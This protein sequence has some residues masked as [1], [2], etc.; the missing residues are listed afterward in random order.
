[1]G[2][3]DNLKSLIS[4]LQRN[5][6]VYDSKDDRLRDDD[7]L[8]TLSGLS[9]L[10]RILDIT[11]NS[12]TEGIIP[13]EQSELEI[14]QT[15]VHDK[16]NGD[17]EKLLE[18]LHSQEVLQSFNEYINDYTSDRGTQEQEIILDDIKQ[19]PT[20][21]EKGNS[22]IP[23]EQNNLN[24]NQTDSDE[25]SDIVQ[26]Y[27]NTENQDLES[28][29][30]TSIS[31]LTSIFTTP[32]EPY[33]NLEPDEVESDPF[34]DEP[35]LEDEVLSD[36]D[37]FDDEPDIEDEYKE[38]IQSE[39]GYSDEDP[40]DDEPEL[41]EYEE[42]EEPQDFNEDPFDDEP[43]LEDEEEEEEEEEEPQ[44]FNEDP[45]DDE[46][47]LEDEY[48]EE[49]EDEVLSDEDPFDDEPELEED[50]EE[51]E[52]EEEPQDFNEDPFDDEPELEEDI[53]NDFEEETETN[54]A[55]VKPKQQNS[56][57]TST[58]QR[59]KGRPPRNQS[60][61]WVGQSSVSHTPKQEP[62]T[63]PVEPKPIKPIPKE[64]DS[65]DYVTNQ[66]ANRLSRL[67]RRR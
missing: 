30:K 66:I 51:F 56:N 39:Q 44:D 8:P 67:K 50:E 6:L 17:Y 15:I 32:Q 1:M 62:K 65:M 60:P 54:Q 36:E 28:P 47:E 22:A 10:F 26:A 33:T 12:I 34:D 13:T 19:P 20:L 48:E 55:P 61:H 31:E 2:R 3:T 45:F 43:E 14:F 23:T 9:E 37:P 27:S 40:F 64:T 24:T 52:E 58:R 7:D 49:S 42:E 18:E 63:I 21:H 4:R 11:N 29:P 35:E 57:S 41:E 46:P 53:V 5:V 59:L 16:Y 38:E 25:N